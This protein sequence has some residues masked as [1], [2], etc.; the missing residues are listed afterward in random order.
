MSADLD[1]PLIIA[2]VTAGGSGQVY[3]L[4]IDGYA[5]LRVH[6][7]ASRDAWHDPRCWCPWHNPPGRARTSGT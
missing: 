4:L 2:S 7:G 6:P 5:P 3:P 1:E